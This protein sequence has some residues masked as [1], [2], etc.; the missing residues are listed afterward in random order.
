MPSGKTPGISPF[1]LLTQ[2]M[3]SKEIK[4][5][6]F[7][8]A[9]IVGSVVSS[10]ILGVLHYWYGFPVGRI[11]PSLEDLPLL[12]LAY[13]LIILPLAI[14]IGIPAVFL[15][16]RIGWFKGSVVIIIGTLTG[17]ACVIPSLGPQPPP[18]AEGL[19]L[20]FGG[21]LMSTL[22]WLIYAGANK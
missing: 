13:L 11:F 5:Q 4:W 17:T 15:L 18:Y 6:R 3:V 19:F 9:L 2:M 22:F 16:N 10:L 1:Q 8:I 21:F 12:A 20:G 7:S 14:I